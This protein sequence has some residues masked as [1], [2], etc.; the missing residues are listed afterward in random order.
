MITGG[1]HELVITSR[2]R[3]GEKTSQISLNTKGDTIMSIQIKYSE[4]YSCIELRHIDSVRIG[5]LDD[6][7]SVVT[8]FIK[9]SGI[10]KLLVDCGKMKS[11][12]YLADINEMIKQLK[13]IN[14][15]PPLKC[16]LV[17]SSAEIDATN[18]KIYEAAGLNGYNIK[19][20]NDRK[21]AVLWL[22]E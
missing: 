3:R 18:E 19:L 13:K 4:N 17:L 7:F 10:D 21:N 8:L 2:Q 22:K 9:K 6:A 5:E 11:K 1:K 20:F 12:H 16:A 14:C 15:Y